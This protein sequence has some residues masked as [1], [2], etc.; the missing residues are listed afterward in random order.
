LYKVIVDHS[1][2]AV[3]HPSRA[4]KPASAKEIDRLKMLVLLF[5]LGLTEDRFSAFSRAA[6]AFADSEA[7]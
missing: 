4:A 3:K 2:I 1:L 6:K 7:Q 5:K